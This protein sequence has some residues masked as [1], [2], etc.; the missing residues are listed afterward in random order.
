MHKLKII[1]EQTGMSYDD[2]VTAGK[3]A[4][5][6]SMIKS[7]I[8]FDV[9]GGEEGKALQDYLTNKALF[10]DGK[11]YIQVKGEKKLISTL[12]DQDKKI[13]KAEMEEKK[14]MKERAEEARTFDEALTNLI[15]QLKIYLLPLI[16]KL[17]DPKDGLIKKLDTLATDFN[18]PGGWGEK[19]EYFAGKVGEFITSVGG[20][21]IE[22]KELVAGL[23]LFSKAVPLV[24]AAFKLFGGVW[25]TIKW[26]KNGVALGEGFNTVASA[27]GGGGGSMMDDVMDMAG[28]G[29]KRGHTMSS[30]IWKSVSKV[31]GG[32]K[33]MV[34]R[35]MRNMSASKMTGTTGKMFSKMAP[36]ATGVAG[37]AMK[38]G[39]QALK[40]GGRV[41]S[42][43]AKVLAPLEVLKDQFD[44][45]SSKSMRKTGGAGWLESLGGSG[46]SLI[47][48]IPGINQL[49]E[50]TGIGVNNMET[51]NL[52]NARAVY[53]SKYPSA[54]TILPNKVLFKDIRKNPNDYPDNVVE[55]AEDVTAED[56]E[57]GII[58][59]GRGRH[60]IKN[61]YG[62]TWITKSGDGLAVSPNISQGGGGGTMRHEF[63]SLNISG[64]ITVNIPGASSLTVELTKD[65][66]FRRHITRMV[67]EEAVK[68][69]NQGKPKP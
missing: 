36:K 61:E 39:G 32:K 19:L 30:K 68:Q 12:T 7:Q 45:F 2:L 28:G 58:R 51:D 14:S 27:G 44:F 6:F 24:S 49:T 50:A 66:S 37:K 9:G 4:K 29:G 53:R 54:P 20:W 63:G 42:K 38:Y 10:Q 41:V 22:H 31:F 25:D 62:K 3:N 23:L 16:T 67:Q 17:S 11:A 59:P 55:D 40:M 56:L 35:A 21:V 18:K 47:D 26:F 60:V 43:F 65:E 64:N 52:A 33:T 34:G 1:A 15:N 48:W 46:M 69:L 57:D 13:L 8:R 5:K